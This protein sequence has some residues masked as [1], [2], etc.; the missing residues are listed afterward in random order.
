[1]YTKVNSMMVQGIDGLFISVETDVSAG[2][3]EFSMVGYLSSEVREARERVRISLKNS[4][5][6]L[7]PRRI[8]VN[9]SPAD[10]RKEG[11]SFCL[12]NVVAHQK[13]VLS[14]DKTLF[15]MCGSRMTSNFCGPQFVG[16]WRE[17]LWHK[18]MTAT[19]HSAKLGE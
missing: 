12:S 15:S 18:E 6:A 14:F 17:K 1:M 19:I 10:L 13:R 5:F 9:L 8:T 4:G 11:T 7:P 2:L 16:M 3:P